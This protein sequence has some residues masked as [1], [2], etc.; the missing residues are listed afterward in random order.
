MT[1]YIHPICFLKELKIS[2]PR[3]TLAFTL[4]PC[5]LK[6]DI[7]YTIA[8]LGRLVKLIQ[9]IKFSVN[10]GAEYAAFA[11]TTATDKFLLPTQHPP[12]VNCSLILI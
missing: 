7:R 1:W 12:S 11:G 8:Y 3:F 2:L 4:H 6:S 9:M 5:Q 10:A